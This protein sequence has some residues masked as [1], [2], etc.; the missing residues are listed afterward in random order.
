MQTV[1]VGRAHRASAF[2][3]R[4]AL[5]KSASRPEI[6]V[7]PSRATQA[8]PVSG[9]MLQLLNSCELLDPEFPR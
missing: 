7:K 3:S 5:R 1:F 2:L 6:K 8:L 9:P 4:T